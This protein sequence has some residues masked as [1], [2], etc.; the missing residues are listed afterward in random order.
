[1]SVKVGL[2]GASYVAASRM[3]PALQ[4]N[5]IPPKRYST[6][7]KSDSSTGAITTWTC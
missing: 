1:M 3:V 2:I 5:G 4:A 6:P 7:I